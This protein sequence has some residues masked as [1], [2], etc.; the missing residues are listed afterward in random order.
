MIVLYCMLCYQ[1]TRV[2][3]KFVIRFTQKLEIS[4]EL[5]KVINGKQLAFLC[6]NDQ[7]AVTS[8]QSGTVKNT[9]PIRI[10]NHTA[11]SLVL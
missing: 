3:G 6:S 10:L 1:K 9:T 2:W 5:C 11:I 4:N 7:V 8:D